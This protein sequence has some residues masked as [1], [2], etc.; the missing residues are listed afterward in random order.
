MI[1]SRCRANLGHVNGAGEP[2]VRTRG[3]VLQTGGVSAICPKCKAG[4][5]ITGEL[6]KALSARLLL[7]FNPLRRAG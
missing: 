1:C 6:A 7:V 2:M 3:L 5:P 4:V